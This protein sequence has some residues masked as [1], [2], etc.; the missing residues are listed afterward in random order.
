MNY[1]KQTISFTH[2]SGTE[3]KQVH[4]QQWNEEGRKSR[5]YFYINGKKVTKYDR[6]E[7]EDMLANHHT[8]YKEELWEKA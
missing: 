4:I 6:E 8:E 3:Y 1:S 2:H 7:C 5:N